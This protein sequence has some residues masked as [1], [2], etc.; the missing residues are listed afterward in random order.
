LTR[1]VRHRLAEAPQPAVELIQ[2]RR[3]ASRRGAS[4]SRAAAAQAT[5]RRARQGCAARACCL[6]KRSLSSPSL[7]CRWLDG[8]ESFLPSG[9]A[10]LNWQKGPG[11]RTASGNA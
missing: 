7:R 4:N 6:V 1:G 2:Q 5:P 10:R 8:K 9:V 3:A 11:T